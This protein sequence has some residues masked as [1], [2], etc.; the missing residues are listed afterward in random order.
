[1]ADDLAKCHALFQDVCVRREQ[2]EWSA[3]YGRGQLSDL[4][5]KTAA[6]MVLQRK[7]ADTAAV[8]TLQPCLSLGTWNDEPI[9]WRLEAWSAEELGAADASVLLDGSGFPKQG[10]PSVGVARQDC[11]HLGKVAQ[12]PHAVFAAYTSARGYTFLDRRLDMPET[13]CDEAHTRV[14]PRDGVPDERPFTTEPQLGLARVKG[15]VARGTIP[16]RWVLADETSGADP[17]FRDGI[18]ALGK[19]D[20]VEVPVSTMRWGGAVEVE[21]AG[22]GPMGRPRTH[23]RVA[24]ETAPRQEARAS[25]AGRPERAGRRDRI[26]EGAKGAVEAAFAFVR[27][28]RSNKG[29]RPGAA[30]TLVLRRSLEDRTVKGLLTNAPGSCPKTRLARLSGQRWPIETACEEAKGAVGMAHD[31]VRTWPG[32]HHHMTQT[33]LADYVV[34]RLRLRGKKSGADTSAGETAAVGRAAGKEPHGRTRHRTHHRP[35][36]TELR[37]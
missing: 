21:A 1:M 30:A 7:G 34:M 12:G 26:H 25:A 5:R 3:F 20:F 2:R 35:P 17:K 13:W 18:E 10:T 16:F 19:W 28:T 24:E 11:G 32:W 22:Q 23:A 4:E 15:L 8:R 9:L 31:E 14:R 27:V 36:G 29:G 33:C 37:S 6:P